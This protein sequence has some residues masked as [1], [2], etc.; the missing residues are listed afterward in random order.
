MEKHAAKP[1]PWG[2]PKPAT[3]ENVAELIE[4]QRLHE[5]EAKRRRD[6][7]EIKSRAE[8]KQRK[9]R[10]KEIETELEECHAFALARGDH[11][12]AA[13]TIEEK[14]AVVK[15]HDENKIKAHRLRGELRRL[16]R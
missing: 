1:T 10:I 12:R 16:K 15:A 8:S 5:L 9:L 14:T 4:A 6:A 2:L 11:V 3:P 7:A 13:R